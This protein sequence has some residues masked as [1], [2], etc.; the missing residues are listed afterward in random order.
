MR[1][2][3]TLAVALAILVVGLGGWWL[4]GRPHRSRATDRGAP[5]TAGGRA[6]HEATA[7]S[8]AGAARGEDRAADA[9]A[10]ASA[11]A[12][13]ITHARRPDGTQVESLCVACRR[14]ADAWHL[15]DDAWDPAQAAFRVASRGIRALALV[16]HDGAHWVSPPLDP[17]ATEG[18]SFDVTLRPGVAITGRV[19]RQ[20]GRAFPSTEPVAVLQASPLGALAD[21]E[22]GVAVDAEGRFHVTGLVPGVVRLIAMPDEPRD[23]LEVE[24]EVPAPTEDLRITLGRRRTV[25]FRIVD[26]EGRLLPPGDGIEGVLGL[27]AEDPED[28]RFVP[29][30][31]MENPITLSLEDER[32]ARFRAFGDGFHASAPFTPGDAGA[33]VHADVQLVL[34]RD[35]GA[36][37]TLACVLHF[38]GPAP[39]DHVYVRRT[40]D[41]TRGF[42]N[43]A[44]RR[45]PDGPL[46]LRVPR[47]E[48]VELGFEPLARRAGVHL[49][50]HEPFDTARNAWRSQRVVVQPDDPDRVEVHFEPC[51][52]IRIAESVVR[53]LSLWGR[54][55]GGDRTVRTFFRLQEQ[56]DGT[57]HAATPPIPAGRWRLTFDVEAYAARL[58]V[59]VRAGEVL[60][61]PAK[62]VRGAP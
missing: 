2:P 41:P 38:P 57:L 30:R 16:A 55:D 50:S 27:A 23:G 22:P 42:V 43:A 53:T 10:D 11:P 5:A 21:N 19:F 24:V 9:V 37:R 1:A 39:P 15:L 29:I 59:D 28:G 25:T 32:W 17:D 44:R 31:T 12:W 45:V 4:G 51:G 52:G 18:R 58:E 14:A 48:R 49:A 20:D 40:I 34:R 60:V 36:L 56:P 3:R 33:E 6:L 26:S 62:A 61:L 13:V 35:A 7:P 46:L 54:L 8:L 47:G